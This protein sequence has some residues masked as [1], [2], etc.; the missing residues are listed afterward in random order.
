MKKFDFVIGNPPYQD[1][2]NETNKSR[3]SLYNFFYDEATK[4]SDKVELVTPA[5]FLFNAGYTPKKWNEKILNDT[6]FKVLKY[7]PNSSL[8]FPN[9]E[10]KGGVAITYRD[11]SK[12]FSP[13][14][15]FTPYNEL[16][17]IKEKVE[18]FN[19]ESLSTIVSNRGLYKYSK[20][21]FEE[22]PEE[23][24]KTSDARI[25]PSSFDR[26]PELFTDEK[27]NDNNE[28][29]KI[30]GILKGKRC[31]KWFRKDYIREV[32]N[33]YKYKVFVPKANGSGAI[34][35]VL[36]TPLI[37]EP[38]IGEPLIGFTETFISIGETDSEKEINAILKYIKGKFARCML[39]ILK[40]TQNNAKPTW[41]YVPLQDFTENSD[42]DWSKSIS[43]IDQQ[44]Y[45][46]YGLS[47]EEINFIEEKIQE[48]E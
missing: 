20:K 45:K 10:I 34:G 16:N 1:E 14:K 8:V 15:I 37:G 21:V 3:K 26:M 25:A 32:D 24:K 9:T 39:G 41:K 35:E 33:L 6:H 42:I 18:E 22:N 2:S 23:M 44:L 43:E 38:L 19:E 17:S 36:S 28:Y 31:Y 11:L 48:M 4:I 5:R 47:E 40:I 13:I 29:V 12:T 30:L 27:P 7:E 46:K